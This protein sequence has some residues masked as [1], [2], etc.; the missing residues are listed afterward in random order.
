VT[1]L[2][3]KTML[4]T[5][6]TNG[7][8]R[9]AAQSLA[10]MGAELYLLARERERGER[11]VV[12]IRRASGNDRVQL[13]LGDLA[14]L[15]SVRAAAEAFL[16]TGRPL[17]VLLNNAGVMN[18]SRRVTDDG[19]EQTWAV[20]HLGPFLLTMLLLDRIKQ[21]APARIVNVSSGAYAFVKGMRWH[22]LQFEQRFKPFPVYGQSKLANI[23]FTRQLARELEGSG[24]TVNAMHPGGVR[25]GLGQQNAG[26]LLKV[27]YKP[28]SLVLRN[29]EKGAETAVYLCADAA[30]EQTSGGYWKDL[31][32]RRLRP[33]ATD[34][35][36]AQQ[37]WQLSLEQT[38]LTA[39]AA[40]G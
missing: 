10:I 31:K 20:N 18:T 35:E 7:I 38:G 39:S 24:V 33:H 23:L 5:G 29:P 17:H 21:S 25:T 32:Q 8:G 15:T 16:A 3:G 26:P 2:G 1:D 34:D 9:S 4:V 40:A 11:A 36:A 37:L 30:V 6:A 13:L 12:E 14:S 28:I 22:D 27:L 19:F